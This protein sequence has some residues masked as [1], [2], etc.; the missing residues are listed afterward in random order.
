MR[1]VRNGRRSPEMEM[2]VQVVGQSDVTRCRISSGG[3]G[4]KELKDEERGKRQNQEKGGSAASSFCH[5]SSTG[6]QSRKGG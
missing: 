1:A 3:R 4:E 6:R 2:R 5:L